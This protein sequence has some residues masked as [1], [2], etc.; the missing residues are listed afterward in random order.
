MMT[1]PDKSTQLPSRPPVQPNDA[2]VTKKKVG[3][4]PG[5]RGQRSTADRNAYEAAISEGWPVRHSRGLDDTRARDP[6]FVTARSAGST[7]AGPLPTI[8]GR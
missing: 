7:A 6:S 1:T 5:Q 2:V 4:R 8:G 3:S